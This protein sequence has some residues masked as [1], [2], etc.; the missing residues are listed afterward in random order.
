MAKIVMTLVITLS[1]SQR[2]EL[3]L[4]GPST[5]PALMDYSMWKSTVS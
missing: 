3:W 2:A 1:M 5:V 4:T